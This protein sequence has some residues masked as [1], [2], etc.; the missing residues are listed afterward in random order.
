MNNVETVLRSTTLAQ[1]Y[2][3]GDA[4]RLRFRVSGAA[5]TTL[6]G[7]MWKI[8]SPEPGTPQLSFTD[9]TTALQGT[10]VVGVSTYLSSAATNGPVDVLLD[11]LSVV[12]PS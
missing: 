3:A 1:T 11:N 6:R 2:R 4:F 10:G 12:R 9:A 8:G 5:P 7:S